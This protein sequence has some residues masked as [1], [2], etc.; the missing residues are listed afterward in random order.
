MFLQ[1]KQQNYV[2][3]DETTHFPQ[4][5]RP[6]FLHARIGTC[7]G[8]KKTRDASLLRDNNKRIATRVASR[9]KDISEFN[10]SMEKENGRE[11]EPGNGANTIVF[12]VLGENVAQ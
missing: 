1:Q 4:Q 3:Y 7:V 2:G 11:K 8:T 12:T 9:E 6:L 5:T 10:I